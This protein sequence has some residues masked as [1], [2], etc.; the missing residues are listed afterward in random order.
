MFPRSEKPMIA[1]KWP[2]ILII[3]LGGIAVLGSYVYGFQIRPDVGDILW[4]G[5]PQD[6]R[7]AYT[8][9]MFLAAAGYFA[10]TYLI[11]FQLE[12]ENIRVFGRF[13]YGIFNVLYLTILIP[14]ALWTPLTLLAV[15][16]DSP[17]LLW[18][19]QLCLVVVGLASISLLF[20][21]LKIQP[22]PPIRIHQ[23][24]V[25]GSII[26]SIHTAILDAIIWSVSFRLP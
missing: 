18:L 14:S 10:Y 8:T 15:E 4:G 23:L 22:R 17:G 7:P 1:K 3:L 2:T 5:V 6:I 25:L 21:L 9:A 19:V 20:T 12:P 24:A 11:L 16:N 13:G 26:F